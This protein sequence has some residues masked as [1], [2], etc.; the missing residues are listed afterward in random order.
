MPKKIKENWQEKIVTIL[1]ECHQHDYTFGT[2]YRKIMPIIRSLL[3]QERE[4]IKIQIV[5]EINTAQQEGQPTSRLTSLYN[6][7]QNL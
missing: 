7:I 4:K 5:K 6:Y 1:R 2:A 3:E